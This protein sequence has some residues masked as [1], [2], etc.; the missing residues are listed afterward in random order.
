MWEK[1]KRTGIGGSEKKWGRVISR[2]VDRG[3]KGGK[4]KE[5]IGVRWEDESEG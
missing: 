2:A 1:G 3:R 4:R 5:R